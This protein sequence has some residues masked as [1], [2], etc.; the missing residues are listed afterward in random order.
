MTGQ[1]VN[2][3]LPLATDVNERRFQRIPTATLNKF[4][5]DVTTQHPP[6]SKGGV[7]VKIFYLTQPGV[8]PPTFVFFVNKPQWVH[9][10]YQ[11]FLEN[12]LRET[13]PLEGTPIRLVFRARSEDRFDK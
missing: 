13:F 12:R 6:P 5:R 1:R 8:A 7:R 3:I 9:F 4:L 2:R 11:R 10:G